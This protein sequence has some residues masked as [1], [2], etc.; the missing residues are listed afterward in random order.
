MPKGEYLN[1]AGEFVSDKYYVLDPKTGEKVPNVIPIKISAR[2]A[3]LLLKIAR[4]YREDDPIFAA[5][6][7]QAIIN[8]GP[9]P[10]EHLGLTKSPD[11]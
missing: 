7:R 4:L 11:P 3:L 5:D 1:E 10:P 6:M 8:A 2:T 9:Y